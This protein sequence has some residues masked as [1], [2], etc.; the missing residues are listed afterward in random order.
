[1]ANSLFPESKS[2]FWIISCEHADNQIP[3]KFVHLFEGYDDLIESHQGWDTGAADITHK[4]A[5]NV[6][7]EPFIYPYTRLLIEPNRSPDHHQLFSKIT[8][9]LHDYEK[10]NLIENYYLPYRNRIKTHIKSA[11]ADRHSV[12]HLSIH[13]FT[14]V[15]KGKLRKVDIGLLYDPERKT[16]QK[17][18]DVWRKKLRKLLPGL[19]IMMNRPYSGISDGL[20]SYLRLQLKSDK[21]IGIELEVNQKFLKYSTEWNNLKQMISLSL[22]KIDFPFLEPETNNRLNLKDKVLNE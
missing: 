22:V 2:P 4:I 13:T 1:M 14:P 5:E 7:T 8:K 3:D 6:K 10:Q 16:E 21:Y 18:C 17:F 15:W 20:T 11:L 19:N 12:I 9:N